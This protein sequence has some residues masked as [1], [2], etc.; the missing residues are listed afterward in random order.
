[1]RH[2]KWIILGAVVLALAFMLLP[3]RLGVP[4]V[5]SVGLVPQE[6]DSSGPTLPF[7]NWWIRDLAKT[8][9]APSIAGFAISV[10]PAGSRFYS[11]ETSLRHDDGYRIE[12]MRLTF[13]IPFGQG[14]LSLVTPEGGPWNDP[15]FA[16]DP[17]DGSI[18]FSV[19]HLGFIGRGTVINQFVLEEL[20]QVAGEAGTFTVGA[21]FTLRSTGV[22]R[23]RETK[24][25]TE[26]EVT[27][28]AQ[29]PQSASEPSTP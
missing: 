12:S 13:R 28:P 8:R 4:S 3:G 2:A 7:Q 1:M 5:V 26:L 24:A 6:A 29:D 9:G 22:L 17:T 21:T 10:Y 20:N 27:L 14:K 25:E 11:L 15:R 16:R 19:E 18:S 23:L